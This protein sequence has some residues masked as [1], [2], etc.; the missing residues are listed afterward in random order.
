MKT[1]KRIHFLKAVLIISG[2]IISILS[3]D[4]I[5]TPTLQERNAIAAEIDSL[6]NLNT[7]T[8]E[9]KSKAY[10]TI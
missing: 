9:L 2:I 8:L 7:E 1:N 4:R 5:K 6:R 10:S 3:C